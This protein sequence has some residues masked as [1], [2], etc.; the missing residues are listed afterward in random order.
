MEAINVMTDQLSVSI[1][2]YILA[3]MFL[4]ICSGSDLRTK[5]IPLWLLQTGIAAGGIC[6][7]LSVGS[8]KQTWT[9]WILSILPGIFLLLYSRF[10]REKLGEADGWMGITI[11]LILQWERCMTAIMT[12]CFLTFCT[13]V[14]FLLSG[15]GK[16]TMQLP[17]APFLLAGVI[18]TKSIYGD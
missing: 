18:C 7:V 2:K 4:G 6:S 5:Q 15:R 13:A 1:G 8:G 12:G 16:K 3:G 10:T 11:G 17:F 9:E 14:L